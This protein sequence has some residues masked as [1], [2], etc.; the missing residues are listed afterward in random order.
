MGF[1]VDKKAIGRVLTHVA[2]Y[3]GGALGQAQ[4]RVATERLWQIESAHETV[5]KQQLPHP[6]KIAH[7]VAG[8]RKQHAVE[9][10]QSP[11]DSQLH[12][13]PREV[14]DVGLK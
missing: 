14:A 7:H 5:R 1:I 6:G 13:V 2:L 12:H 4:I 8:G 11:A 9:H 3:Q 10:V